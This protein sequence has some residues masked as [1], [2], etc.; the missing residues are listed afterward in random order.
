MKRIETPHGFYVKDESGLWH[1]HTKDC[2]DVSDAQ[3]DALIPERPSPA[4]FWFNGTPAP[5]QSNDILETL[6][7]RWKIWNQD[8][9]ANPPRLLRRLERLSS[10]E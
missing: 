7:R 8:W 9:H 3:R 2:T 5:M 1:Y 10:S 4:W 6:Y